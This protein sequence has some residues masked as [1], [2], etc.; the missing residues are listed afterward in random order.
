MSSMYK[1]LDSLGFVRI[2]REQYDL[3][4]I[5]LWPGVTDDANWIMLIKKE[6]QYQ[7]LDEVEVDKKNGYSISTHEVPNTNYMVLVSYH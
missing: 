3:L 4:D 6:F 5:I 7:L 1:Q 2:P